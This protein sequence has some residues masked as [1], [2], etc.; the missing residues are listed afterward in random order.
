MRVTRAR[1]CGCVCVWLLWQL[2][3]NL[4]FATH[5]EPTNSFPKR[6]DA[7]VR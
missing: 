3:F 2:Y 7:W 1:V 5:L 4:D 6:Y